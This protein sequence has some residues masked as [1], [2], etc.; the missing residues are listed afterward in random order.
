MSK[1]NPSPKT[2]KTVSPAERRRTQ[3]RTLLETFSF[4]AMVPKKGPHRLTVHDLSEEGIG[5]DLDIEGEA[6]AEFPISQGEVFELRL[7]LNQAL[8]L[9]LL[10]EVRRIEEKNQIRRIGAAF[11]EK[12]S[13]G[14]KA[15][16]CLIQMLDRIGDIAKIDPSAA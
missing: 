5:F 7:Y 14:H 16:L 8:Y 6:A 15:C 1:A 2:G 12:D 10:I 13:P 11:S 9:P 3:R 4:F